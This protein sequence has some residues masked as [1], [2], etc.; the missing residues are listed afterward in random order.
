MVWCPQF[1]PGVIPML[2]ELPVSSL[3]EGS[4]T[5]CSAG[6]EAKAMLY[7]PRPLDS[8]GPIQLAS[9][10]SGE[11]AALVALLSLPLVIT[12][13]SESD[14]ENVTCVFALQGNVTVGNW[15][16]RETC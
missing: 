11:V 3:I 16:Y 8:Y 13:L 10:L 2:G 4:L 9:F 15:S 7:P 6:K 12:G 14:M 1:T 5:L